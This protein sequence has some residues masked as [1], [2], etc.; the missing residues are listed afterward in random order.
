MLTDI[1]NNYERVADHCSNIAAC[2][3]EIDHNS[4]EIHEYLS[5]VKENDSN[6]FYE[7]YDMYKKRYTL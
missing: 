6:E 2:M 3:L 4:F 7:Y 1:L 5:N